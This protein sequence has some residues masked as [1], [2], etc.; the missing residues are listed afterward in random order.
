MELRL[1]EARMRLCWHCRWSCRV[2]A[3]KTSVTCNK[4]IERPITAE[5][6]DCP[7]YEPQRSQP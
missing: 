6:T 2:Y 1:A 4:G 7:Y 5:G 3:E